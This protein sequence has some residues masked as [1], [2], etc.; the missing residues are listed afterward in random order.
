MHGAGAG[1]PLHEA[2]SW[3]TVYGGDTE[4]KASQQN[5]FGEVL[6]NRGI[7]QRGLQHRGHAHGHGPSYGD[8]ALNGEEVRWGLE[9][10]DLSAERLDVNL[11]SPDFTQPVKVTCED[12]E[13]SGPVL[14]SAVERRASGS[15]SA[16]GSR[17]MRDVVPAL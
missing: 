11:A 13:T 15:S 12:H 1:W 8:K 7:H 10:L 2:K 5:L 4:A 3:S 9:N 17:P 16:T 6:Y 14:R